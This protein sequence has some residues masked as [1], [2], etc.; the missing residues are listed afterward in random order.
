MLERR[1]AAVGKGGGVGWL[2]SISQAGAREAAW[3]SQQRVSHPGH[4]TSNSP[5]SCLSLARPQQLQQPAAAGF[6]A[7]T[8][9]DCIRG[10][11][12]LSEAGTLTQ[13]RRTL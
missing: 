1:A 9:P 13:G 7:P 8:V 5:R 12:G 2:D 11:N 4:V 3:E 10:N 6:M